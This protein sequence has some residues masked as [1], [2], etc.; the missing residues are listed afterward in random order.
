MLQELLLTFQINHGIGKISL[1]KNSSYY[2]SKIRFNKLYK[3]YVKIFLS[4]REKN[5][6]SDKI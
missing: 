6:L 2:N 4:K 5:E 1:I 3:K